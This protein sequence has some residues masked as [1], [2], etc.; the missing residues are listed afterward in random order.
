MINK[1]HKDFLIKKMESLSNALAKLN[2]ML[3]VD[4]QAE[5][6]EEANEVINGYF[7]KDLA[8]M[9]LAAWGNWLTKSEHDTQEL[10]HLADILAVKL[11]AEE[12]LE[13]REKWEEIRKFVIEER[14]TFPFHWVGKV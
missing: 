11:K 10:I 1:R 4:E 2:G 5:I 3:G 9:D 12:D 6:T 14:K 13:T 7:D 8:S